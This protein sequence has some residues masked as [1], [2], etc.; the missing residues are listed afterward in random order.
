MGM[1]VRKVSHWEPFEQLPDLHVGSLQ[2]GNGAYFDVVY[3]F[4]FSLLAV[5]GCFVV[6]RNRSRPRGRRHEVG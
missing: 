4:Y 6:R 2:D 5:V 3:S 1:R